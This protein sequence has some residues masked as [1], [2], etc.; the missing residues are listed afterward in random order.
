MRLR[1]LSTLL[2]TPILS[3]YAQDESPLNPRLEAQ[4]YS[5]TQYQ[6]AQVD[7]MLPIGG[8]LTHNLHVDLQGLLNTGGQGWA[9]AG[10]GF[11]WLPNAYHGLGAYVFAD[12]NQVDSHHFFSILSPGLEYFNARLDAR[13]NTYF[14]IGTHRRVLNSGFG[15]ELG[16]NTAHLI[17]RRLYDQ[18][19]DRTQEVGP[20][21]DVSLGYHVAPRIPFIAQ[22]G[23]YHFHFRDAHPINGVVLGGQFWLNPAWYLDAAYAYDNQQRS[24][25]TLSLGVRV[26]GTQHFYPTAGRSAQSRITDPIDRYIARSSHGAIPHRT[27]FLNATERFLEQNPNH[28]GNSG[29]RGPDGT[30]VIQDHLFFF[31]QAITSSTPITDPAQCT[32]SNPCGPNQ[33]TQAGVDGIALLDPL[34]VLY[35]N[36]GAYTASTGFNAPIALHP[37]QTLESRSN[38]FKQP[39]SDND[40][41]IFSG[42][43]VLNGNTLNRISVQNFAYATAITIASGSN[44]INSSNLGD[45]NY[46]YT[47]GLD[48]QSGSVVVSDSQ[49]FANTTGVNVSGGSTFAGNT[50]LITANSNLNDT[51][52]ITASNGSTVKLTDSYVSAITSSS[53]NSTPISLNQ[54][55]LIATNNTIIGISEKG[56]SYGINAVGS[57]ALI[58]RSSIIA[59]TETGTAVAIN[60]TGSSS[61][62]D[63]SSISAT[64]IGGNASG[65]I[66]TN[67][68]IIYVDSLIN[69]KSQGFTLGAVGDGGDSTITFLGTNVLNLTGKDTLP[70]L[71]FPNGTINVPRG[72]TLTC[73]NSGNQINCFA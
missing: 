65:M 27:V 61:I 16:L 45:T 52:G 37:N 56:R 25:A 2:L 30:I 26:G 22:L 8:D 32:A 12:R 57:S 71:N 47:T 3:V 1:C 13:L 44:A 63:S 68:S 58:D 9:G 31:N 39:A 62:I 69:L 7:G 38:D 72:N 23:A 19:I 21:L 48:V 43:F 59:N 50:S 36:G 42:G 49:I 28:A 5:T 67:S 40:R 11:R 24:V 60:A 14:P 53:G 29:D 46:A 17:G 35:F 55:N 6:G 34:A 4:V 41:T 70:F 20:G 66:L 10:L 54:A 51:F 18:Y 15:S 73:T 64:A 33:F